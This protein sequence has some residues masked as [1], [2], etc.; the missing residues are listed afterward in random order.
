MIGLEEIN[1]ITLFLVLNISFRCNCYWYILGALLISGKMP[2]EKKACSSVVWNRKC[3][4]Q[5]LL[6]N[7]KDPIFWIL[8]IWSTL[9][10]SVTWFYV[11]G[12]WTLC[13][14][15]FLFGFLLWFSSSCL[16]LLKNFVGV[17][18]ISTLCYF[19]VS[20]RW[21]SYMYIHCFF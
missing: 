1:G 3:S 2:A 6:L 10:I 8:A 9:I 4:W 13:N 7:V 5:V 21:I 19:W 17:E 16:I 14:N 15:L 20:A 11:R 18:L 12:C